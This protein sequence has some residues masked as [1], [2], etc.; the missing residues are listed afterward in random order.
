[1]HKMEEDQYG[2]LAKN[3]LDL[4]LGNLKDCNEAELRHAAS[5]I[6]EKLSGQ[7]VLHSI[8]R[9][10]KGKVRFLA[11]FRFRPAFLKEPSRGESSRY[12]WLFRL[13]PGGIYEIGTV[14]SDT[15]WGNMA[16]LEG[17]KQLIKVSPMLVGLT[18]FT[19]RMLRDFAG[20]QFDGQKSGETPVVGLNWKEINLL[21]EE[22][23]CGLSLPSE[24]QWEYFC[25]AGCADTFYYGSEQ[26]LLENY[27]WTRR[28]SR[29]RLRRV[30]SRLPNDFGLFDTLGNVY[31]LCSDTWFGNYDPPFVSDGP[32]LNGNIQGR[33]IRGGSFQESALCCRCAYRDA[34]GIEER[35]VDLGFR[36]VKKF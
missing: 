3:A 9:Q 21:V 8:E 1:M 12:A 27:A 7:F 36:L 24:A 31:E 18:V 4:S 34:V 2:A 11:T 23:G 25:R 15:D 5:L 16:S 6:E 13:I 26:E 14:P 19:K 35:R 32:R 30:A 33:V 28:N 20:Q 10:E 17:P 29:G 22:L